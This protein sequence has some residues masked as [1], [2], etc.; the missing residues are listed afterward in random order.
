MRWCNS[1]KTKGVEALRIVSNGFVDVGHPLK[2]LMTKDI[3]RQIYTKP[4]DLSMENE[5]FTTECGS[6]DF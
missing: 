4:L 5:D 2:I 1:F 3:I 6:D